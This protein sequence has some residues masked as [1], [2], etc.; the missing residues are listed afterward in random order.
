MKDKENGGSFRWRAQNFRLGTETSFLVIVVA[1]ILGDGLGNR[2]AADRE[3]RQ[4][5]QVLQRGSP[6]P[7][8][9]LGK[10]MTRLGTISITSLRFLDYSA[11][12]GS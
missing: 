3:D 5:H 8:D 2:L 4:R 12:A 11:A 9:L 6:C 7:A 1:F 10:N